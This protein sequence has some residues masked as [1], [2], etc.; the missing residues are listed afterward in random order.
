MAKKL[1]ICVLTNMNSLVVDEILKNGVEDYYK[2]SVDV[3]YYDSSSNDDTETVIRKYQAAGYSNLYYY[4][5]DSDA[6]VDEKM[7]LIFEGVGLLDEYEYIWPM[8]DRIVFP[9]VTIK[10]LKKAFDYNCDLYFVGDHA[11]EEDESVIFSSSQECYI[12]CA[13]ISTSIGSVIY[14]K[15]TVLKGINGDDLRNECSQPFMKYFNHYYFIFTRVALPNTKSMLVRNSNVITL[16]SRLGKSQWKKDSFKIWADAWVAVN[17]AL[18]PIY[19]NYKAI[20][21]KS[22]TQLPW[23]LGSAKELRNIKES[24]GFDNID[25][26]ELVARWGM[27]SDVP[28]QT[29]IHIAN[30]GYN[31]A[32]DF[33]LYTGRSK[34]VEILKNMANLYKDGSLKRNQIPYS[35]IAK[36]L[37]EDIVIG[38][39]QTEGERTIINA[40]FYE[41]INKMKEEKCDENEYLLCFSIL[42]AMCEMA[43][44][45]QDV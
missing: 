6:Y 31:P 28:T 4:R 40:L 1:A 32:V 12:N 36:C 34:T 7:E 41:I 14:K 29:L 5:T 20:I 42:L 26:Q 11:S 24:G 2:N 10:E 3:Y 23:I 21:I 37:F 30:G 27:L 8:K 22:V 9:D 25:L 44:L 39:I 13:S 38:K 19:D 15:N 18:P 17:E 16:E 43:Y 45:N 33:D 35:A